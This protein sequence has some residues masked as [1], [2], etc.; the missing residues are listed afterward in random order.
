MRIRQGK[1]ADVAMASALLCATQEAHVKVY[2]E[3]YVSITPE[4]A[5]ESLRS[6]LGSGGFI[7]AEVHDKF[8]GYAVFEVIEIRATNFLREREYCYLQ[9]IGIVP[10]ARGKGVGK[11]LVEHVKAFC[12]AR[13]IYD[14]QVD[15]W[16]F[17]ADAKRFFDCVGFEPY[18]SKLRLRIASASGPI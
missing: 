8:R 1:E 15:V 14:I 6:N 7:V 12:R 18:A 13:S 4:L 16:A 9:Q 11:A 5:E 17:N 10:E 2:P 3:R